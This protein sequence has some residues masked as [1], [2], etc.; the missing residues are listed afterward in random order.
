MIFN[1]PDTRPIPVAD[2]WA[3]AEMRAFTLSNSITTTDQQTDKA[4]YRVACPQ[5]KRERGLSKLVR[6][7]EEEKKHEQASKRKNER[8]IE[9][10]CKK[11]REKEN[12][13]KNKRKRVRERVRKN[14]RKNKRKKERKNKR[15][16]K[17]K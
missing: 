16:N 11:E 14:E 8:A 1:W 13:R 9:G 3:G 12:K 10:K 2:G 5:L 4:F 6:E 7:K 15:K 17:R